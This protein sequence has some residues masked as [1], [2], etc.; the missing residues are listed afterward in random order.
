MSLRIA[1]RHVPFQ[2]L[3]ARLSPNGGLGYHLIASQT[4]TF[5]VLGGIG[6]TYENYSTP[7]TNNFIN[8]NV[9]EEFTHNFTANTSMYERLYF[10]PYLND[11]GNYPSTSTSEFRA[12][13]MAR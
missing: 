5:D 12:R 13:F 6:Y 7:L 10:F 4:T 9:G 3:N 2:D 1:D 8:A 11:A